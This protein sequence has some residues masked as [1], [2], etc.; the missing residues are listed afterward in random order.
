MRAQAD[1]KKAF[2]L[3]NTDRGILGLLR[4]DSRMQVSE[5]AARLGVSRTTVRNRIDMMCER[6]VIKRFTIELDDEEPETG[7]PSSAFFLLQLKRRMCRIIYQKIKGWPE[8]V[9]AWSLSGQN[10]MLLLVRALDNDG[11]ED[12][13]MRLV[14]DP[15]IVR[16]E[17]IVV[18]SEWIKR[19]LE[20]GRD[21]SVGA[22]QLADG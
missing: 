13:R 20:S 22:H 11:I 5:M 14:R 17:T 21:L 18:L 9:Q 15:E 2:R 12:L 7:S 3:N 19:S 16:V 1:G 4:E 8:L 6:N 10:D